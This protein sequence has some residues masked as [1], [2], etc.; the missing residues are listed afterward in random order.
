M[1]QENVEIARRLYERWAQG[2]F[3][4]TGFFDPEIVYSRIGT[5]TPDME[6]EWRGLE[7]MAAAVG[8]YFRAFSDLRSEAERII[9]L[10][11]DKVLV[12][13]RQTA[14]GK[15]SGA[16]FDHEFAEVI[17]LEDGKIVGVASYWHRAEGLEA[18]GLSEQ[19]AH[20]ES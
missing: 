18:V 20:A 9:D 6:G 12:L 3:S 14:C 15:L 8:E 2:D 5:D 1:S 13:S 11:D 16:P 10:G 7:A 19:D 4:P 17:T